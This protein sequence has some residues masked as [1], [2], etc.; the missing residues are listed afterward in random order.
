MKLYE[1]KVEQTWPGAE[2]PILS[3]VSKEGWKLV[4]VIMVEDMSPKVRMYFER[5]VYQEAYR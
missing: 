1:Y 4:S 5:E 2:E 3:K